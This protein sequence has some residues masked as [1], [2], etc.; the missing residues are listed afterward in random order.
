MGKDQQKP[1]FLSSNLMTIVLVVV[2]IIM[3]I[4]LILIIKSP[5]QFD[6]F[7][8]KR[9]AKPTPV[10]PVMNQLFQNPNS[11]FGLASI[12]SRLR[13]VNELSW[14]KAIS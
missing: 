12:D 13:I 1:G 5:K 7:K 9:E 8:M 3:A 14:Q 11:Q 2:L 4:V 10:K 6:I